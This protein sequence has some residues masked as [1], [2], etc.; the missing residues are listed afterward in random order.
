MT[1]GTIL[2]SSQDFL[3]V[4]FFEEITVITVETELIATAITKVRVKRMVTRKVE[5]IIIESLT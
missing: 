3:L 2:K 1:S 4:L 5:E